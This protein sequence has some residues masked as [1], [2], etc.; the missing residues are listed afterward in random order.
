MASRYQS[1][2]DTIHRI[3]DENP[4]VPAKTLARR[5]TDGEFP[6]TSDGFYRTFLSTYSVI[7]RYDASKYTPV[8]APK[9]KKTK[10]KT[11]PSIPARVIAVTV[12]A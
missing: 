5:I 9:R 1:E 8:R 12:G 11:G 7:R 4:K 2:L 10:V 3:R 6:G